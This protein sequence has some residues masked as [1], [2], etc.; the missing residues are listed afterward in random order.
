MAE[1][2]TEALADL[3]AVLRPKLGWLAD[4][5]LQRA[6]EIRAGVVRKQEADVERDDV[7]VRDDYETT[8]LEVEMLLAAVRIVLVPVA[9]QVEQLRRA[10]GRVDSEMPVFGDPATDEVWQ[11]DP[12]AA[13]AS[14]A[15]AEV[16]TLLDEH[17]VPR[18]R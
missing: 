2:W 10:S 13:E 16:A 11:P 15:A 4:E 14:S 5:A 9:G 12:L 6:A 7:R 1:S 8:Q 17:Q 18:W 3:E